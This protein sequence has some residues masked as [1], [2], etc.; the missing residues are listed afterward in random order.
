M[1]RPLKDQRKAERGLER[2]KKRKQGGQLAGH[3]GDKVRENLECLCQLSQALS[4]CPSSHSQP[5]LTT[6]RF[7]GSSRQSSAVGQP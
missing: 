3:W 5:F 1:V 6:P 7:S 4:F 2:V